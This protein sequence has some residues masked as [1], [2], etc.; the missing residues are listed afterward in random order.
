[1]VGSSDETKGRR[2]LSAWKEGSACL[3]FPNGGKA[4]GFVHTKD[5]N[6]AEEPVGHA[7]IYS[8][9]IPIDALEKKQDETPDAPKWVRAVVDICRE[10]LRNDS[11]TDRNDK[12]TVRDSSIPLSKDE[13]DR[14]KILLKEL[15]E[16]EKTP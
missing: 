9:K 13:M 6:N 1:M 11:P 3:L 16:D 2:K 7:I 10:N 15:Q 12:E 5:D 8:I 4:L 14:L